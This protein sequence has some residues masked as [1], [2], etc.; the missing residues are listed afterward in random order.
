MKDEQ[1]SAG[2][3]LQL[4]ALKAEIK[5]FTEADLKAGAEQ[6]LKLA[7]PKDEAAELQANGA[8]ARTLAKSAKGAPLA[9]EFAKKA[10]GLLTDKDPPTRHVNVL[11]ILGRALKMAGK[12]DEAKAVEEKVAKMEQKLDEEFIKNNMPFKPD[13]FGGRTSKSHRVVLVELFTGAQCPPCVSADIAFD[14][15][16]HTYKY[17]EVVFLEYHLHI[18]GPDVL[19]NLETEGRQA[20]Y[21]NAIRGTPTMFSDGKVTPGM[22]GGK[23]NAEDRY[24]SL[25]ELLNKDVE[26]DAGAELKLNVKRSGDKIEAT[27]DVTDLKKTGDKVR[28]RFALVE[29]VVRYP[30]GNGQRLH[31]HVVRAFLGGIE[32]VALKEAKE[33]KTASI[34]LATLR[35]ELNEYIDSQTALKDG[36]R[37][38]E[39]KEL[40]IV[41]FIQDDE[42][43]EV[44]QAVQAGVPED[45]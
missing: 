40:K 4:L 14:A 21:G 11:K 3:V 43:K 36:D 13:K 24:K 35:K 28:L 31:H 16:L 9:V 23:Q 41:A 7:K 27:A 25:C 33:T 19:T 45:K 5:S 37:P 34:D 39:M 12:A 6:Y 18:P 29:E 8:L 2:L 38:L 17:N 20:Y 22:G 44:V 42:N 10:E 30:G 15:A 32:G 26:K 1:A